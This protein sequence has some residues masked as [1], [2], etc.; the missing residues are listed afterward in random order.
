MRFTT[1]LIALL[2]T[3]LFVVSIAATGVSAQQEPSISEG[4]NQVSGFNPSPPSAP[5][6]LVFIHH[7][8]G[9]AWL[10]DN[11]GRLGITLRCATI[12][13]TLAIPIMTGGLPELGVTPISETGMTGSEGLTAPPTSVRCT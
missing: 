2:L 7:S 6:R 12:T 1:K 13:T 9:E 4:Q 10:G 8:T 11:Y 3:L 5:V